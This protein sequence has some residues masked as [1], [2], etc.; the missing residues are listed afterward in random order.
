MRLANGESVEM[1]TT[2]ASALSYGAKSL[3]TSLSSVVQTLVKAPGKKSSTT[4]LLR[5]DDSETVSPGVE[6]RVKSGAWVPTASAMRV[7]DLR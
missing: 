7:S 2:V 1:P 5:S 3:L 6:G 4:F